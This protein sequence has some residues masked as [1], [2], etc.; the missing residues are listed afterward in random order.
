MSVEHKE[1]IKLIKM[2][3]PGYK[4]LNRQQIG[5]VLLNSIYD[6]EVKK[7]AATLKNEVVCLSFYGRSNVH[8]APMICSCVTTLKVNVYVVDTIDTSGNSQTG[9]YL[10]KL[11]LNTI[12]KVQAKFLCFVSSIVT[13]GAANMNLMREIVTDFE[14]SA[15]SE[16]SMTSEN[17]NQSS[18]LVRN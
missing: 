1:F 11:I 13:D 15:N 6:D 7:C 3:R 18:E 5:G 12:R 2:L 8:N 17:E 10:A 16:L 4:P 9:E 14:N